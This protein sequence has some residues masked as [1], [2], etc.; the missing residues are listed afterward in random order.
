MHWKTTLRTGSVIGSVWIIINPVIRRHTWLF[1]VFWLNI[2]IHAGFSRSKSQVIKYITYENYITHY[3]SW[4]RDII[5]SFWRCAF[6]QM[7]IPHLSMHLSTCTMQKQNH[8]PYVHSS[9]NPLQHTHHII[10]KK[11]NSKPKHGI[12]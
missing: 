1:L 9:M 4:K 3:C 8:I 7:H 12:T 6:P 10:T 5:Q 11:W 2:E